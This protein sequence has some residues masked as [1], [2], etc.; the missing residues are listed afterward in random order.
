MG[1]CILIIL[2]IVAVFIAFV[3]YACCVVGGQYDDAAQEDYAIW[4]KD[5]DTIK[6]SECGFGLFP[7]GTYF[8]DGQCISNG[9]ECFRPKYCSNCGKPMINEEE[10]ENVNK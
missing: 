3:G 5:R 9:N 7:S 8:Q 10:K 4:Y 1:K 6:C 2:L